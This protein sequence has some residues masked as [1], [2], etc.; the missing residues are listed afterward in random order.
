MQYQAVDALN[1][2]GELESVF[3]VL[4]PRGCALFVFVCS[5]S[6]VPRYCSLHCRILCITVSLITVD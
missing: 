1:L 2:F 5:K 4:S 6:F 3:T